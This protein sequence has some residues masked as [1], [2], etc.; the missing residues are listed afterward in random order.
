MITIN[1]IRANNPLFFLAGFEAFKDKPSIKNSLAFAM[2]TIK[3]D[4]SER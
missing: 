3:N 2:I 1:N 4:K